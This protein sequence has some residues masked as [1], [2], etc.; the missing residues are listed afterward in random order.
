MEQVFEDIRQMTPYC[1]HE[2]TYSSGSTV[3]CVGCG[4]PACLL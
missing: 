2:V 4:V 3:Y 1:G